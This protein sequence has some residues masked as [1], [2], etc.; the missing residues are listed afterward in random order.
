VSGALRDLLRTARGAG[1]RISTAEAIDAVQAAEAVG[2]DDRMTLRD[3]LRLTLAKTQDEA[4]IFDDC[5]DAFFRRDPVVAQTKELPDAASAAVAIEMAGQAVGLGEISLFTQTGMY[6]RRI[7]QALGIEANDQ[8]PELAA[9]VRAHVEARLALSAPAQARELR[10]RRLSSTRIGD[11]DRRDLAQLRN[12]VRALARRLA[13]RL[14]RRRLRARRGQLD[15]RRTLRRN[16]GHD[17]VPFRLAWK[18]RPMAK[19]RIF[20]LCDVSGSV[21]GASRLLLMFLHVLADVLP[22]TR[23]FAFSGHLVEVSD[24]L[25]ESEAGEA[26]SSVLE[27]IGFLSTNYGRSL[28]DFCD[29]CLDRVDRRSTVIILGDGRGNHA[30][31]RVDLL[32]RIQSQARRVIWLNPEFHNFWGSGDSDML[33]YRPFCARVLSCATLRQLDRALSEILA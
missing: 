29:I 4:V 13:T 14:T 6:T 22:D 32:R 30:P 20:A 10:E 5:F 16:L 19:P 26:I 1:V 15:I 25:A 8:A 17:G 18:Q 9:Q 28:E 2:Y 31:P 33:L 24:L 11:I 7:M 27:K 3:A 21:A 12:M 23:C